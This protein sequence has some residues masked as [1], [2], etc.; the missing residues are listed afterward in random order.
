MQAFLEKYQG[1]VMPRFA[2]S[3]GFIANFKR[4]NGFSSRRAHLK[5]RPAVT[6]A[7]RSRWLQTMATLLVDVTDHNRII[8]VDESSW[9]VHPTGL[10]TWAH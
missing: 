6:D 3:D 5:R 2:C 10:R 9:R 7:D 4:R 1:E 8:N